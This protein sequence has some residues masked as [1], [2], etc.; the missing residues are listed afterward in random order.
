MTK[1]SFVNKDIFGPSRL[2]LSFHDAHKFSV[3][4]LYYIN[5]NG[6]IFLGAELESTEDQT[7][8]ISLSSE[9]P[10]ALLSPG[11]AS[12]RGHNT[13]LPYK[14]VRKQLTIM[15]KKK[16]KAL[17]K[18]KSASLAFIEP[19]NIHRLCYLA[20]LQLPLSPLDPSL[21]TK[22]RFLLRPEPRSV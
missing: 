16:H 3:S 21:C 2:A 14:D 10:S 12:H 11:L 8:A 4:L 7:T 9:G 15:K 6:Y 5:H 18:Y 17:C 22:E 19:E 20:I 1:T 13:D